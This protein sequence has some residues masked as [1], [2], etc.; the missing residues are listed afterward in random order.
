MKKTLKDLITKLKVTSTGQVQ[1]GFASIRGGM[2]L[3]PP[4]TNDANCTNGKVGGSGSCSGSNGG[5][6][7]NNVKCSDITN[8]GHCVNVYDG[9]AL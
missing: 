7:T 9:C 5:D 1:G 3:N 8:G 4:A 6:C 2:S